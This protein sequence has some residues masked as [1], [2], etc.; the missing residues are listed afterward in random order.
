MSEISCVSLVSALKSNLS[1][2]LRELELSDNKLQ[3]LNVKLLCD[4]KSPHCGLETLRSV[5]GLS[6]SILT[7]TIHPKR[8]CMIESSTEHNRMLARHKVLINNG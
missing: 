8:K 5:Q 1:S 3:D 6:E 4:R 7:S 2:H